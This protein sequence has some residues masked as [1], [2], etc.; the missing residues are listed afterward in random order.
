ML[1][2]F[3]TEL[4]IYKGP[5]DFLKKTGA[6]LEE[7]EMAN[8]LILGNCYNLLNAGNTPENCYFINSI[9][10]KKI[11]AS[12][13]NISPKVVI[14]GTNKNAIQT[15][16]NFYQGHDIPLKGVIGESFSAKTFAGFYSKKTVQSRTTFVQGLEKLSSLA[17]AEGVLE[18]PK[19]RDL[20]FIVN[21]VVQFF[22]EEKLRPEKTQEEIQ[23]FVQNLIN[24][25]DLFLHIH[26]EE[27]VGMAGIIRKTRNAAIIGLVYTPP[28]ARGKGFAKSCV[29]HLSRHILN[30][31]FRQSGLLVYESNLPARHIYSQIGYKTVSELL[32]I[33]FE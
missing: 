25:K 22:K 8:N 27:P 11:E 20:S 7:K 14:T 32:D 4:K 10:D 2:G 30:T 12:C 28:P 1:L 5:E 33:D 9:T 31:G 18:S 15:I 23:F 26:K 16:S 29:H 6:F 24:K 3:M 21:W 19:L 13:I 17:L